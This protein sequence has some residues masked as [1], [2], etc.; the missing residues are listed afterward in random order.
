MIESPDPLKD[1]TENL[2][3]G[4]SLGRDTCDR[5]DPGNNR[6]HSVGQ[7][8]GLYRHSRIPFPTPNSRI[9]VLG[10][11]PHKD[12]L[13]LR[14]SLPRRPLVVGSEGPPQNRDSRVEVEW[15]YL[16]QDV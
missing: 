14:T 6:P 13:Q 7:V 16:T 9:H 3:E 5:K 1:L 10:S 8:E 4:R 2:I 11:N 12:S 15:L